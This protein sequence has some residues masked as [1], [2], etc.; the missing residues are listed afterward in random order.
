VDGDARVAATTVS[1]PGFESLYVAHRVRLTRLARAITLDPE[2]A[3]EVMQE[4]FTGLHRRWGEVDN[5]EAYVQRSVVNLA[6]KALRRRRTAGRYQWPAAPVA[7][8]PEIDETWTAVCALPARQRAVVVLRYWLD[9][10]EA[11]IAAELGWRRGTVKSSLHRALAAL[12]SQ[13]E[14]EAS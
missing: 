4:A 10:S 8:L 13:L 14:K 7:D 11:D 6:V 12:R 2:L 3:E 5:P 9:L 1:E